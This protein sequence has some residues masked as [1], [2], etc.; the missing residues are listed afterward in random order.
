MNDLAHCVREGLLGQ[1]G[2][3]NGGT[4]NVEYKIVV[5]LLD[6]I[7]KMVSTLY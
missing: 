6:E 3:I 1:P 7:E 2:V 5:A 4:H